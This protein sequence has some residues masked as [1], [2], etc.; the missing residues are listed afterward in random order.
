MSLRSLIAATILT[1]GFYVP[2]AFKAEAAVACNCLKI[3]GGFCVPDPTCKSNFNA[4]DAFLKVG[5]SLDKFDFNSPKDSSGKPSDPG[6]A[7]GAGTDIGR[8]KILETGYGQLPELGREETGYGLYSYAILPSESARAALFLAKVFKEIPSIS[9][10]F[11]QRSQLNIFYIPLYKDKESDFAKLVQASRRDS[12]KMG[13]EFAKSFYDYRMARTILHHICNKPA[14]KTRELCEGDLS[15]GP[16]VFTYASPASK[17][18]PVVPPYLFIDLSSIDEAAF[19]ELIAAF[20]AQV[21]RDDPSDMAKIE[22]FRLRILPY[23]LKAAKL[24]DPLEKAVGG[25]LNSVRGDEK[26][27]DEKTSPDKK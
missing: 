7:T 21:K 4:D 14:D 25:I 13:T 6:Y 2:M 10:N 15:R 12:D 1:A 22:T 18:D 26:K 23:I 20:K 19:E 27:S 17:L 3:G 9:D 8:L 5:K 11:T 24:V 16:Y